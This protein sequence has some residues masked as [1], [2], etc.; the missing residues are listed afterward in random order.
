MKKFEIRYSDGS[1][2]IVSS[3]AEDMARA[4]AMKQKYGEPHKN[5]TWPCSEWH[6]DG[7]S[8]KEITSA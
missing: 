8:V 6:G 4:F 5:A 2:I 7:L 1:T 3:P